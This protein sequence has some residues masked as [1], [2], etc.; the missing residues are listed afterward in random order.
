MRKIVNYEFISFKKASGDES[1]SLIRAV[2]ACDTAEDIP[3]Y[4]GIEGYELDMGSVAW[5]ISNGEIYAL[6]SEHE[7]IKQ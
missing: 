7:W 5:D 1:V 6:N 3:E 4:N 2:I